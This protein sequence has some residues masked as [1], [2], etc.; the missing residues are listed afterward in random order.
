MTEGVNLSTEAGKQE[1]QA[2]AK[3]LFEQQFRGNGSS[4]DFNTTDSRPG[5][6]PKDLM[7]HYCFNNHP[8]GGGSCWVHDG[9]SV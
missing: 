5:K 7:R 1:F 3:M 4:P 2:A 6:N 9:A 8:G